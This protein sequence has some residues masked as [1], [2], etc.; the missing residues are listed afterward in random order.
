M[1]DP[2]PEQSSQPEVAPERAVA[3]PQESAGQGSAGQSME[4]CSAI[5]TPWRSTRGG[6][7]RRRAL[8]ST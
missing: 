6:V 8:R 5:K 2:S 1:P 7:R 4:G 3:L